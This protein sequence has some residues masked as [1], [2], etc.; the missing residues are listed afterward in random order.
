MTPA[1]RYL[2]LFVS[3]LA[4]NGWFYHLGAKHERNAG[5]AEKLEAVSRAIDQAADVARQDDAVATTHEEKRE[6][7]RAVS[8]QLD[9]EI[10]KNVAA[11]PAYFECG[12]DADGLREWNSANAGYL[13]DG[14]GQHDA[15]VSRLAPGG[16]WKI[17]HVVQEPQGN[18]GPVLRMPGSE[19]GQSG[20]HQKP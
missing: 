2:I 6:A 17:G 3:F 7:R 15:G 13:L 18:G 11:N 16:R 4:I 5:K 14:A 8:K 12:L 20:D 19:P 9:K 1:A 10:D